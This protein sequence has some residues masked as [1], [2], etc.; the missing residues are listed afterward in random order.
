M[1]PILNRLKSKNKWN[2]TGDYLSNFEKNLIPTNVQMQQSFERCVL[3]TFYWFRYFC[4]GLIL[5]QNIDIIIGT[6]FTLPRCGGC[7]MYKNLWLNLS[8]G[9]IGCGRKHWDGSGGNE[10]ALRHYSLH[11]N[12]ADRK[13]YFS[14]VVKLGTISQYGADVFDYAKDLMVMDALF[15]D[16]EQKHKAMNLNQNRRNEMTAGHKVCIEELEPLLAHWGIKMGEMYK[17]DQTM[18]EKEVEESARFNTF[19]RRHV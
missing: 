14:M 8:D 12:E 1:D 18:A 7:G 11:K 17:F 9:F 10:C 16:D 5:P 4:D 2:V 6:F 3:V 15:V 13:V 19:R